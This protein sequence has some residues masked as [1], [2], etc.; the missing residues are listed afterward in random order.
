MR[1][2]ALAPL[3]LVLLI[4]V[5]LLYLFEV[6]EDRVPPGEPGDPDRSA[7]GPAE[8]P[9]D[10]PE[11]EPAP[12]AEPPPA[13][14]RPYEGRLYF[15]G[16]D[17]EPRTFSF[18]LVSQS[19]S[20]ERFQVAGESGRFTAVLPHPGRYAVANITTDGEDYP[21]TLIRI[22]ARDGE[23]IEVALQE[24]RDVVLIAVDAETGG[25]VP[26]ARAYRAT[27]GGIGRAMKIAR[28]DGGIIHHAYPPL[29]TL[30]VPPIVADRDGRIP[31]GADRGLHTYYLVADGYAWTALEVAFAGAGEV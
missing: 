14:G 29:R 2:R 11:P 31:L 15:V 17:R 20:G 9:P 7:E 24:A 18:E 5:V 25:P 13:K 3:A 16:S 22:V 27:H 19:G 28:P 23:Q 1:S 8:P 30:L 10:A 26:G 21:P 4:G 6:R 12:E